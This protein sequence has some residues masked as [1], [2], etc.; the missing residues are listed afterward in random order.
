M[1]VSPNPCT[2]GVNS[3][4]ELDKKL[5]EMASQRQDTLGKIKQI[6]SSMQVY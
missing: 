4:D 1:G 3:Y 6:E 5:Q 2:Y